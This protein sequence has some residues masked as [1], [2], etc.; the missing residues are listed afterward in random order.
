MIEV[1]L[2]FQVAIF[3]LAMHFVISSRRFNLGDPL[4]YYLLF[5]GVFFVF[6]P[7]VVHFFEQH[8]VINRIGFE[9]SEGLFL[10]TLLC[11]DVGLITWLAVGATMP[12]VPRSK[13]RDVKG[14]LNRTSEKD[15]IALLAVAGILGP[16]A[17]YS[18]YVGIEARTLNGSGAT[19]LALDQ[20][21]GVTI[22]S[23]S[24]GY[25]NDAQ[26]MLGS[27]VLL[28][29]VCVR[30]LLVRIAILGA[31]LIVRLSIGNDRWTI[32][33]L[34]CS[35]G[36]L[37][38]A[39]R[40]NYNIPFW[41]YLAA[42]PAFAVFTLLG[43]ARYFI[44]DLLFGTTLSSG[45]TEVKT[46]ID[47][48]DGPDI[49][50]FEFLAFIT[51][52]VPAKTGTYS[53]FTQWLQLFT[54]PIPRVLWPGK[55]VGA[56]VSLFSLNQYGNFFFYSRGMIGDAYMSLGIPGIVLVCGVFGRLIFKAARK[57]MSGGMG[58]TG[59]LLGIVVLPL[60]IQW[61]RDG[62]VVQISKFLMWNSLPVL[63][64]GFTRRQL[65]KKRQS[66]QLRKA[67]Q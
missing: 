20:A 49:A 58:K 12:D 34:L 53:Y 2:A 60:I 30:G 3:V 31:F 29:M 64:W 63:L 67:Y 7:V 32:V 43:E 41:I 65:N 21:T 45:P 11:S 61:L 13:L 56:P 57:L 28:S 26:Y 19:G 59:I 8:F 15:R 35:L 22:N 55:P 54:E 47:R 10:W 4:F 14:L 39:K 16:V 48:L 66:A 18:A 27:L 38:A 46:I 62:G 23:T 6:R 36:I 40:G 33:F 50:N 51:D 25:L 9:L 5:H 52:T 37:S 44:R 17:L 42:I 24:T 1:A